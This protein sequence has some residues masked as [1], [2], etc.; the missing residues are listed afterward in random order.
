[1]SIRAEYVEAIERYGYTPT[2]ARFLYLVATHSGYFTQQ[3]FFNF[4]GVHR[5]GMGTR[6]T[7]KAL[8]HGH[9]RTARLARHT[10]IYNLFARP[11][12]ASI[13]KDNLRNRRRLSDELIRTRLLILDFVL[14]HPDHD[15][16]ETEQE[17]VRY[18]HETIDLPLALLPH[19]TYKGAKSQSETLR[20]FVDRFPIF[21]NHLEPGSDPSVPVLVYCDFAG[22]SLVGFISYLENY[23]P[24]LRCLPAFEMVYAAPN[25]R[26]LHR[27]EAFSTRQYASPPPV[28]TQHLCRYFTVRQ[29]WES[30]KHGSLTRADRDLL[31]DGDKRYQG[32][33]F[34][35]T[36]RDWITKGL[37][38]TKVNALINPGSERPKMAFKTH[39]LPE[40]YD[41]LDHVSLDKNRSRSGTIGRNAHSTNGSALGSTSDTRQALES[42]GTRP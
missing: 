9:I 19:R 27:A 8:Q 11:F 33:L 1:M 17:K 39:L 23:R 36:Y 7:A 30:H 25:P 20:Y 2:E 21:L 4:A 13:D 24:L 40:S 32:H 3:Q 16:L 15:Y 6:L 34:D 12:Y 41:I 38:P 28:D 26:K 35:Q 42:A 5:G 14:A 31:R 37:T 29:L 22:N 10:L 18:F